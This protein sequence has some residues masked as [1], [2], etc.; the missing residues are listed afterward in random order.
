MEFYLTGSHLIRSESRGHVL[1]LKFKKKRRKSETEEFYTMQKK[2]KK[3][4]K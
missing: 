1:N 4:L 3:G 2:E